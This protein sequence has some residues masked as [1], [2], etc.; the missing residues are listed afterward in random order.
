MCCAEIIN[1]RPAEDIYVENTDICLHVL[2]HGIVQGVSFRAY[3]KRFADG[4]GVRGWI[5]NLSDGSVEA[6]FQGRREAVYAVLDMCRKGNP[7][8]RVTGIEASE[9]PC[10][11]LFSCFT[12]R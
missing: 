11:E 7:Y 9:T 5:R 2:F 4:E 10:Q 12:I 3:A 6:V 8:A 1:Y